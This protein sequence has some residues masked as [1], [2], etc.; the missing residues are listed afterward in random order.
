VGVYAKGWRQAMLDDVVTYTDEFIDAFLAANP[1][2][3][4]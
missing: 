1:S 3:V 2:P 4:E